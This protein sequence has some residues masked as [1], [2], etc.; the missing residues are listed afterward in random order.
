M[1]TVATRTMLHMDSTRPVKQLAGTLEMGLTSKE[2][3]VVAREKTTKIRARRIDGKVTKTSGFPHGLQEAS[4]FPRS[5]VLTVWSL[6]ELVEQLMGNRIQR[7]TVMKKVVTFTMTSRENDNSK[8]SESECIYQCSDQDS[9]NHNRPQLR[10]FSLLRGLLPKS[11]DYV[12]QKKNKEK[13]FG[14]P[15]IIASRVPY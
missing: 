10:S 11:S 3:S 7:R 14:S 4:G 6:G 8:S 13:G 1:R 12:R 2:S 15:E 9:E 5:H